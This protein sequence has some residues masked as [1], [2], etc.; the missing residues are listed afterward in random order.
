MSSFDDVITIIVPLW[1]IREEKRFDQ[2]DGAYLMERVAIK[3][4]RLGKEHKKLIRID[5]EKATEEW[6]VHLYC[7]NDVC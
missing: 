1:E 5:L 4:N 2:S 7:Q 6:K 3:T